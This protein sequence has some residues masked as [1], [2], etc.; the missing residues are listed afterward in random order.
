MIL[1]VSRLKTGDILTDSGVGS[2]LRY[3]C[4]KRSIKVEDEIC[5]KMYDQVLVS[6]HKKIYTVVTI[7]LIFC[8]N[9]REENVS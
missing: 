7:R 3:R 6:H 8:L 1:A 4:D 9:V 5:K 2:A